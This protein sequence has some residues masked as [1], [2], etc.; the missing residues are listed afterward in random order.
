MTLRLNGSSSGYTEID[1]PAAAGSNTL[2]LPTSNGSAEQF[3]KNS[4]TAGE[5]E[6]SS[7]VETST[8]VGI[9]QTSPAQLLHLT[10][11]GS[12]AFLQFSDSGSGGSA[13]QARIGSSGNDLVVLNNTSS[14]AATE[15]LRVTSSGRL[16]IGT[17]SP[18][19]LIHGEVS[20][21]S[22][23]LTLKSTATSGEASVSI[24]GENSSGTARTGIF[25]FDNGDLFR[26]GT[27]ANI[28]LRLET[29]DTE[30]LRLRNDGRM[31][32]PGVYAE[33]TGGSANVNVQSDGLLQRSVSSIKYK[34]DVETLEDSYADALLDLRPVWYKSKCTGDNPDHGH[35]GF[36]AEELA[37][38]DPRLV[39]WKTAEVSYDEDGGVVTT[40][41]DPEPEGVQY[42]RFVPHLVNLIK[43]QKTRIETLET[44]NTAQQAQIDD[45]LARVTALEST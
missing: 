24:T 30:R 10:S 38:I 26:L 11:T 44:Q 37:E 41:C 36:I 16:A 8:G 45:L 28:A 4:G 23:T 27:S 14:N 34:K 25:K 32:V 39:I 29:N 42:E 9:G 6:F 1:A 35:W 20:S 2:T 5:L 12:N 43:R 19:S 13:A 33:T 15:R 17:T 18:S 21:G 3:L 22:A 40:I 31:L 7:M